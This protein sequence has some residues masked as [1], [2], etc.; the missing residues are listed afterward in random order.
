M[1][2]HSTM[3][4]SESAPETR[5]ELYV[6][7]LLP[8]GSRGR[9]ET[10]LRRLKELEASGAVDEVGV[11]VWGR[12]LDVSPD[13][14]RTDAGERIRQRVGA[15]QEWAHDQGFSLRTCFSSRQIRSDITGEEYDALL[16]PSMALAAFRE[17]A[18]EFVAPS[19][20]GDAVYTVTDLLE[21]FET[22]DPDDGAA[23]DLRRL[24]PTGTGG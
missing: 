20:D 10:T 6:R 15:F 18:V 8:R 22:A 4:G 14:L 23:A 7:S 3:A 19:T 5:L 11:V 17:D 13:A 24:A 9:Q 1:S 21:A 12:G 2:I 16:F